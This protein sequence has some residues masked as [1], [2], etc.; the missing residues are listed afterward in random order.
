MGDRTLA[1]FSRTTRASSVLS[2][3]KFEGGQDTENEYGQNEIGDGRSLS[4]MSSR[5]GPLEGERSKEVGGIGRPALG[6]HP[7]QLKISKGPDG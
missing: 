2:P 4:E 6:D 1:I 3:Q 7:D 5:D